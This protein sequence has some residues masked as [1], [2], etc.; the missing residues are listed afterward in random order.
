[1]ILRLCLFHLAKKMK[2]LK[3]KIVNI[4]DGYLGEDYLLFVFGSFAKGKIVKSSD[5]DLAVYKA[6][7][8]PA[9]LLI[10]AKDDMERKLGTLRDIDVVN[11]TDKNV[12][13]KLLENILKEGIIW[14]EAKNSKELLK[15]LKK[16]LKN[17]E[18]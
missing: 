13:L 6:I 17:S 12:G 5:I 9:C 11:L 16:R 2:A 14:R 1:K 8:I 18:K 10:Q 3:E 4:L 15:N 7:K